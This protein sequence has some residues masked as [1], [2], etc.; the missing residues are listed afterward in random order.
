VAKNRGPLTWAAAKTRLSLDQ[1]PV[2]HFL[3]IGKTAGTAVTVA[4]KQAQ[5]TARYRVVRHPHQIGLLAVPESDHYFFCVRDP[6]DRYVSGFLHREAQGRPRY[7]IPWSEEEAKAFARFRSPDALAVS[8]S[9]GG[10]EQGDAEAAMRAIQHVRSSYWDWFRDPDYFK[11]RA[12][13]ILWIGRQ[14]CLDLK[15]LAATL[16]LERLEL[17]TDAARA[18]KSPGRKPELSDLARQ[19][20][21]EWY[22]KDYLFLELCREL[23]PP[24]D[25]HCDSDSRDN[26]RTFV[27]RIMSERPFA[28]RNADAIRLARIARR[29][30]HRSRR[31]IVSHAAFLRHR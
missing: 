18:N 25:S 28:L 11:S 12:D 1:R 19:N 14:E 3:H 10:T 4:L 6:I 9:A 8:L 17:P 31:W 20:L 13:H 16:G 23:D 27:G 26:G 29:K 21:R 24:R 2:A 5:D 22:A 7:S 15:P 30:K